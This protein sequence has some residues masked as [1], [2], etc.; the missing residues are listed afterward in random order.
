MTPKNEKKNKITRKSVERSIYLVLIVGLT[1][2][3]L[4]NSEA[5][6]SLINAIKEAFSLLFQLQ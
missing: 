3:G 2:Y 5:A 1:V 6:V 4:W